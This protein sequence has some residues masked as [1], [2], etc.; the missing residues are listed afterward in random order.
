MLTIKA[1]TAT[2]LKRGDY[3]A[4]ADALIEDEKLKTLQGAELPINWYKII[5]NGKYI[6]AEYKDK[7]KGFYNWYAYATHVQVMLNGKVKEDFGNSTNAPLLVLDGIPF[8]NQVDSEEEPYRTCNTSSCAM[9]A[10]Y[11]GA[12]INS[13]DEYKDI[14]DLYGDTTDHGVQTKALAHIGIKSQWHTNLD[15]DD[16]DA[17]LEHKL[18][19]C[20]GIL[21]KGTEDDP[22]GG[23]IIVL[24]GK[25]GKD[26]IF[27]DPYGSLYD[28]YT[29]SVMNGNRVKYTRATLEA[30]WQVHKTHNGWGRTFYENRVTR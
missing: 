23:H 18:P 27:H 22:Y 13:D 20:L 8:W 5:D 30:R 28:G 26:Y 4:Q 29:K 6:L 1:K 11:L 16:L 9:A 7:P 3:H 19:M 25:Q 14:V 15:F 21:H 12:P 10:K 2:F 17:S 24:I